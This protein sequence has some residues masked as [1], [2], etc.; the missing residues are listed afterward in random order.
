M[1]Q[2]TKSDK[3][4]DYPFLIFSGLMGAGFIAIVV[5]LIISFIA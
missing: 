4:T 2:E 1:K 5:Y 3:T